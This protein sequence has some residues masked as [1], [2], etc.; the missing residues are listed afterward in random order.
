MSSEFEPS[1]C[2]ARKYHVPTATL[3][4]KLQSGV[5]PPKGAV[6]ALMR[7]LDGAESGINFMINTQTAGSFPLGESLATA[8]LF[9]DILGVE[10]GAE[11]THDEA[12]REHAQIKRATKELCEK[13]PAKNSRINRFYETFLRIIEECETGFRS[14]S[15]V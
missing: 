12:I 5:S 8:I 11:V 6:Y 10:R 2:V 13:M 4:E 14:Y 9:E 1:G 15:Y 7:F 3:I